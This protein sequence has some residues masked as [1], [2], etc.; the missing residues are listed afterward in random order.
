ME[1]SWDDK[2]RVAFV[3][4]MPDSQLSEAEGDLLVEALT[5]WMGT[6]RVPFALIGDA[7]EVKGTD[8]A[9]RARIS[10]F[11]KEHRDHAFL[12]LINVRP[13][14]QIVAEMFRVGTGIQMKT[15]PNEA[16]AR[17]WLRGKGIGA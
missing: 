1:V 10:K 15:F 5:R 12:A 14:L 8:G 11:F 3:R 16:A 17:T 4:Y 7:K 9:Y 6:A 13:V 2:S